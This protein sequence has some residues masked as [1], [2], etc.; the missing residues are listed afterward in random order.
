LTF[1]LQ[2]A[3]IIYAV[4]LRRERTPMLTMYE[5]EQ[6]VP[7]RPCHAAPVRSHAARPAEQTKVHQWTAGAVSVDLLACH[8]PDQD[9]AVLNVRGEV[10]IETAPA[11]RAAL[12]SVLEHHRGP[13]V[14]D[15]SEVSFMDSTGVHVLVDTSRR[16]EPQN[17]RLAI[18][19]REDGQV[20]RLLALVDLLDALTVHRS[21]ESAVIGGDDVL[22]SQPCRNRRP[23]DTRAL[24]ES[25]RSI[26][27][28]N[29]HAPPA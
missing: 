11:L 1:A 19:C 18:A 21:R 28:A 22:R 29:D 9:V 20:H 26:R 16:L 17:R 13:V 2:N 6:Q 14:M 8:E 24:T 3:S 10:D 15:L 4:V 25:P 7:D 12:L 27:P 23:Y 5:P